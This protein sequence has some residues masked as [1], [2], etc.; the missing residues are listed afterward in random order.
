MRLYGLNTDVIY[1]FISC[2]K[3][4]DPIRRLFTAFTICPTNNLSIKETIG[5][6]IFETCGVE[7]SVRSN[8]QPSGNLGFLD[9]QYRM[10]QNICELISDYMYNGKLSTGNKVSHYQFS[11]P[12]LMVWENW[13]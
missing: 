12:P 10:N 6:S 2:K 4:G 9:T 8:K 7:E 5:K 3:E 1:C 11:I 13:S